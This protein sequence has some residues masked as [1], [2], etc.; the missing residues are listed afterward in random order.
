MANH[1]EEGGQR[2]YKG[3]WKIARQLSKSS[4]PKCVQTIGDSGAWYS[5][6][7]ENV[8][9]IVWWLLPY[10][11]LLVPG[12]VGNTNTVLRNNG[13]YSTPVNSILRRFR[14][15]GKAQEGGGILSGA[16]R[17]KV[18]V[19]PD[20]SER[21]QC[22]RAGGVLKGDES[23]LNGAERQELCTWRANGWAHEDWQDSEGTGGHKYWGM[24]SEAR[25]TVAD[26][27]K[28]K[29]GALRDRKTRLNLR[30]G[31]GRRHAY[32]VYCVY[33]SP[34]HIIR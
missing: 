15:A 13:M 7:V 20:G 34:V 27:V 1:S 5:G 16:R 8:L 28:A 11:R 9:V 4:P 25:K 21:V 26:R 31:N 33:V 32:G 19:D 12:T 30:L 23:A 24:G 29:G 17:W 22:W 10:H 3:S 6:V 18:A 2:L 14:A